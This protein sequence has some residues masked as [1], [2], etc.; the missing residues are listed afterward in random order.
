MVT[1]FEWNAKSGERNNVLGATAAQIKYFQYLALMFIF[2]SKHG[3][4]FP[5]FIG[6]AG[7]HR[8]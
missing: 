1:F 7:D 4:E 3:V 5:V 6:K 2:N 8:R